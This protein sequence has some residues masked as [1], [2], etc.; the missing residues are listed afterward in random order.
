MMNGDGLQFLTFMLK[1]M[2]KVC[3]EPVENV[4]EL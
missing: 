1:T 2:L 3:G 4:G